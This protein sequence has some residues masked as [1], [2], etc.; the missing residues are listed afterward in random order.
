MIIIIYWHKIVVVGFLTFFFPPSI[1]IVC[2]S[3]FVTFK[4]LFLVRYQEI[5]AKNKK[6]LVWCGLRASIE[7]YSYELGWEKKKKKKTRWNERV[8]KNSAKKYQLNDFHIIAAIYNTEDFIF[9]IC[10]KKAT[11]RAFNRCERKNAEQRQWNAFFCLRLRMHHV[12]MVFCVVWD[13]VSTLYVC[14]CNLSFVFRHVESLVRCAVGSFFFR[15]TFGV[16]FGIKWNRL[17]LSPK[18]FIQRNTPRHQRVRVIKYTTDRKD[19][20]K[21]PKETR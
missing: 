19:R 21:K 2:D 9:D 8:E 17:F 16:R 7:V 5:V 11:S 1:F 10:W 12:D 15:V 3:V 18:T 6:C 13:D 14:S 20:G 4:S